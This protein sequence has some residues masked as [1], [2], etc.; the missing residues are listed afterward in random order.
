MAKNI[1]GIDLTL[2]QK[3]CI[4]I[5]SRFEDCEEVD[6]Q[7]CLFDLYN[8]IERGVSSEYLDILI[9]K[10]N[11]CFSS[12]LVYN[13]ETKKLLEVEKEINMNNKINTEK[14]KANLKIETKN[15]SLP[16]S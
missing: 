2:E 4:V 1:Y 7:S 12:S 3:Y 8:A 9:E 13:V 11:E 15:C 10:Y 6:T 14:L 16:L 5:E